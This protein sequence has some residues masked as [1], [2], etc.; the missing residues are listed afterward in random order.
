MNPEYKQKLEYYCAYQERCHSEVLQ[1]M[2]DLN[3][4][5]SERDEIMVHLI[6][7]NF[8]NETRFAQSFARGKHSIKKWGR[9]RIVNELKLRKISS[10]NIQ[11]ALKEIE[12]NSYEIA[13]QELAQKQWQSVTEK[14]ILKKKKKVA[15]FLLRKG[16]ES[17]WIYDFINQQE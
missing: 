2:N 7:H 16:Y 15:D 5:F 11:Q 17:Q 1:K 10:Y 13:F 6:E 4:P 9:N 3:I 14:N 8:L 12:E